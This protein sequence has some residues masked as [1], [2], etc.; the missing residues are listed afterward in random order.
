MR[1]NNLFDKI[2]NPVTI[3]IRIMGNIE[4]ISP[5]GVRRLKA[6]LKII[7]DGVAKTCLLDRDVIGSDFEEIR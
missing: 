5:L 6:F 1:V 2:F 3:I 4:I 7:R